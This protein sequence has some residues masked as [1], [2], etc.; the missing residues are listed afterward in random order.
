MYKRVK[1]IFKIHKYILLLMIIIA[2]G[3]LTGC[4][5][6]EYLTNTIALGHKDHTY[7]LISANN[8]TYSLAKYDD[9]KP[10]FGDYLM[11]QKSGKWGFIDKTGKE[12]TKFKYDTI[13]PMSENK[14]VVTK[15]GKTLIIDSNNQVI[16]TFE[17]NTTSY[18]SFKEIYLMLINCYDL[19]CILNKISIKNYN[20]LGR[21][22][23]VG[24][25]CVWI[26]FVCRNYINSCQVWN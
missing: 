21:F 23:Y 14:A 7:Y 4:K 3:Y 1:L 9:V 10:G 2:C 6:D 25:I 16:Y 17:G 8:K 12:I 20:F 5:K 19:D 15:D 26:S 13:N 22:I 18:S 11:V 24:F